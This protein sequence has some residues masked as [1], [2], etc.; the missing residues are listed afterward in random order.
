MTSIPNP[1]LVEDRTPRG[2][3][4]LYF[5][6]WRWHFYA[7]LFVIP[8]LIMLTFTGLYM[9]V[10]A[11]ASNELGWVENVV[12]AGTAQPISAQAK[13]A[14]AAMPGGE[15]GTYIAPEAADRPAFFEIGKDGSWFA[16]AVDP[17]TASVLK[18]TNESETTRALAERIHGT[19]LLGN[20]GDRLVEIAASLSILLVATGLY[21]WWPRDRN[22]ARALVPNLSAKGRALWKELHMA[23]G[24]WASVFLVLFLLSGLAWSGIWGDSFVKPW[25]SFPAAKWDDVPLSDLTHADLD[26]GVL[27]EVPWGLEMTPL[28]ASGSHVGIAAIAGAVTLDSVVQ[29]AWANGFAGQFKVGVPGSET[30]VYTV[31]YDGRNEDTAFP[32]S[33]RFVHIDRYTGNILA[34]VGYAD[35]EPVGKLMALGIALHKGTAGIASFAFNLVYLAAVLFICVSG[36]VMWWKRR[37]A[38]ARL[39]AP[40]RPQEIPYAKGALL[41]TLALSLAFP[42]LGVTLLAVIVLDLVILSLVPPLK[43]ALS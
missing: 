22:F 10:Y 38:G 28:P 27:H 13:A 43:R 12:V 24:V 2:V 20:T 39:G 35:Y 37:P 6:A 29:W 32:T 15:F 34:D 41:I 42:M 16:V 11:K 18:V 3:N 31:S 30:G 17:Y 9:M 26:H 33:D 14:L 5:A 8:F 7:G 1:E 23:V 19:I 4:R 40:P 25:S 21:L 36:I